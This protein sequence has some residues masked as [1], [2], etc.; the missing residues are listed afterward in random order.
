MRIALDAMGGDHAPAETVLGAVQAARELGIEVSLVGRR[1]AIEPL[2]AAQNVAGLEL[3]IVD[4]PDVIEMDEHAAAAVRGKRGSSLVVGL[5]LVRDG[6][7]DAFVSAGNTGAAM[8]A[9]YFELGRIK[10]IERP[11]LGAVLPTARGRTLV[12]DVGANADPRP[13]H[14]VQFARMGAIYMEEVLGVR[15]PSVGLLSNGEEA[16]KGNKLV[17]ETYPLLQA[18][19]LRFRGNVEG[20]DVPAGTVDVVVCD[21]FTGNVLL[22]TAE[23]VVELLMGTI[24]REL[25]SSLLSKLFAAGLLPAFRRIRARLDY[26]EYG[27]VPLLGVNGPVII[28]HGRSR[29]K[30]IKNALRVANTAAEG[31]LVERIAAGVGGRPEATGTADQ[32]SGTAG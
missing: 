28:A 6:R 30:A 25:S 5:D 19:G 11:A 8:A 7:A 20:R 27:G 2:L 4:A 9:A 32:R 16:E 24:R 22:K 17:Q 15:D 13:S 29:A 14:L 31:R 10:G 12:I 23:G 18:S 26:E 21:G 1:A 3:S